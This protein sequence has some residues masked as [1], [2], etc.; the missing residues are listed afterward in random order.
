[1][2]QFAAA[3][4]CLNVSPHE[5]SFN[6]FCTQSC[7]FVIWP[8]DAIISRPLKETRFMDQTNHKTTKVVV[9]SLQQEG[10]I[11]LLSAAQVCNFIVVV[12]A[13]I[14]ATKINLSPH[15]WRSKTTMTMDFLS[16]CHPASSA[17]F[18][19]P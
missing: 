15:A 18:S 1:L 4:L 3:I 13:C 17:R 8:S 19:T 14:E 11:C 2:S 10:A 16:P 7:E 5:H 9:L 6:E 12:V